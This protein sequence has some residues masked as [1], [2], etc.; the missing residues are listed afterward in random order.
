GSDGTTGAVD[1]VCHVRH[2]PRGVHDLHRHVLVNPDLVLYSDTAHHISSHPTG[3]REQRTHAP[4]AR[5]PHPSAQS[6][7][8]TLKLILGVSS[9]LITSKTSD[10]SRSL[11][12]FESSF[13]TLILAS[14]SSVSRAFAFSSCNFRGELIAACKL[15]VV[16]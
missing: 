3:S 12:S 16:L 2:V 13:T 8:T 5:H 1:P 9:V 10:P 14:S 4:G 7:S 6:G 15:V 11:A